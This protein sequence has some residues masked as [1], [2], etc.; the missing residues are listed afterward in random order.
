MDNVSVDGAYIYFRIPL[1]GGINVT[2]TMLSV[3]V[4]T[5]ALS[6]AGEWKIR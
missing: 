4:V 3:L 2:Q 5:V 1:F 6:L